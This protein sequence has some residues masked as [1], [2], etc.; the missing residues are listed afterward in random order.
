[1]CR[2]L[3]VSQYPRYLVLN[4]NLKVVSI[5]QDVCYWFL[6][7]GE[8][9]QNVQDIP[10]N[11][12][13][14]WRLFFGKFESLLLVNYR[15]LLPLEPPIKLVSFASISSC[16]STAIKMSVLWWTGC[17]ARRWVG[18]RRRWGWGWWGSGRGGGGG[19]GGGGRDRSLGQPARLVA[20]KKKKKRLSVASLSSSPF[21]LLPGF[22]SHT[23][24]WPLP[25]LLSFSPP[26]SIYP[27]PPHLPHLM[28]FAWWHY[29]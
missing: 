25:P 23:H 21:L 10:Q 4:F 7:L 13:L 1:M 3:H 20:E 24:C 12:F 16:S 27:L 19:E 18:E 14:F 8:A 29:Q 11:W 15:A 2:K 9:P 28:G 6:E 17:R 5:E 26:V 22:V